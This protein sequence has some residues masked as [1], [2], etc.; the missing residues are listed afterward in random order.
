MELEPGFDYRILSEKNRSL[1]QQR[2]KELKERLQRT[3]QDIWEIGK[4][5]VEVRAELKGHG[6][7]DAWLRAEFGW[8]RRTAYNF[9]YVYEA[10]PYAKFAQMIIEPSALYRLAS[11][12]TPD[13]IRDKFI[14]QA[15][16]G[17][18]VTH[19]EVLKAVT[20]EKLKQI[21]NSPIEHSLK[22]AAAQ[23]EEEPSLNI[24]KEVKLVVPEIQQPPY[25]A[26]A[27]KAEPTI[28]TPRFQQSHWYTLG[29]DHLLFCG[30][31]NSP[32]FFDRLPEAAFALDIAV[33]S[34][35]QHDW[36]MYKARSALIL[37][38]RERIDGERI[39][40]L[41]LMFS[42]REDAIIL[43]CA[44]SGEVIATIGRLKRKLFA[45]YRNRQQCQ[46]AIADSGLKA[47]K[48]ELP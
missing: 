45:G 9:I 47:Q 16:A 38:P 30:D 40:Q 27:Y 22:S 31:T 5:L 37:H 43:P 48:V 24:D 2:T 32:A 42:E 1:V 25:K 39:R 23:A 36:L 15:N 19:K 17:S 3:A 26:A 6:Y 4:K 13:A 18:K 28:V 7:F 12:S 29:M 33:G 21:P 34:T 10:F 35:W 11:P 8:S 46:Q 44:P 20:E 41:L 14:Q